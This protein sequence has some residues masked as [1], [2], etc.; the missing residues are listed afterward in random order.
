M[1]RKLWSVALILCLIAL[2]SAGSL[3]YF[4]TS[5]SADNVITAGNL[6]AR[7]VEQ[8]ADGSPFPA[9]GLSGIMPGQKVAKVVFVENTGD[10]PAYIRMRLSKQ[11][12]AADGSE[13]LD[14][15]QIR[16]HLAEQGWV[17][18]DGW[19]YYA[20]ALP[21]G[22]QT[23]PLLEQVEFLS[24]MDN[25]YMECQ[26]TVSVKMQAVQSENNG[27]SA[28]EAAGWPAALDE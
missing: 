28:L 4:T 12:L 10:H 23:T 14:D 11:V 2:L 16:L 9:D 26:V 25:S 20:E 6:R 8:T 17:E 22:A 24:T 3:A 27:A 18:Q 21:A 19:Y 7:L 5:G 15:A 13:Q 1:K